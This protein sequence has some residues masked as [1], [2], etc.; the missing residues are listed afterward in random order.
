MLIFFLQEYC[1]F[2]SEA[3]RFGEELG[4]RMSHEEVSVHAKNGECC[5]VGFDAGSLVVE[6]QNAVQGILKNGPELA[7]SNMESIGRFLIVPAQDDQV[8]GVERYCDAEPAQHGDEK[9][10]C[11]SSVAKPGHK[12]GG[13]ED[14]RSEKNE[15]SA[16]FEPTRL[17]A[18]R[19]K[20]FR[21]LFVDLTSF[22]P[23]ARGR[24]LRTHPGACGSER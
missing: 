10:R 3:L 24:V 1:P 21:R 5:R 9:I 20:F 11:Q 17:K 18:P 22:L 13:K 15:K 7:P 23:Q 19:A 2:F 6:N 8:S 12:N 14:D 16:S 4:N